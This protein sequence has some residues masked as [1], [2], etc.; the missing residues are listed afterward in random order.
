MRALDVLKPL[1]T[2][3]LFVSASRQSPVAI[4]LTWL[5]LATRA[6][7]TA[8]TI[9]TCNQLGI[10]WSQRHEMEQSLQFLVCASDIY[11]AFMRRPAR[12]PAI[13]GAML[14]APFTSEEG[15]KALHFAHTQTV[16]LLAQVHGRLGHQQQAAFYCYQTLKLQLAG[17]HEFER[18]EWA[19]NCAG[20]SHFYVS[21]QRWV[22]AALCLQ[23]SAAMMK[24]AAD[25]TPRDAVDDVLDHLKLKRADV[26][27]CWLHYFSSLL[28][29]SADANRSAANGSTDSSGSSNS[30]A[31]ESDAEFALPAASFGEH[32]PLTGPLPVT[33][34]VQSFDEAR[35]LFLAGKEHADAA[36][37]FYTFEEHAS[38]YVEIQESVSGLYRSLTQFEGD[39]ERRCKMLKARANLLEPLVKE[40]NPQHY[41]V[42]C[43]KLHF[44]IAE[45]YESLMDTRSAKPPADVD[46]VRKTNS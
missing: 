14:A 30:A 2:T 5:S 18:I 8:T 34:L 15:E 41:A 22:D 35:I 31:T 11:D 46:D 32:L 3:D 17:Q 19:I 16:F 28:S 24:A 39:V 20:L 27:R 40:L 7:H 12:A 33:R 45:V 4:L 37:R 26:A 6:Q 21:Q 42:V 44:E 36:A 13:L 23:A 38:D 29:A 1:A 9:A 10:V 43:R 25:A